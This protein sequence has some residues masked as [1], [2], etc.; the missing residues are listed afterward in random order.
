MSKMIKKVPKIAGVSY[1]WMLK[2]AYSMVPDKMK[3]PTDRAILPELKILP[4]RSRVII[5][6]WKEITE[7]IP[8]IDEKLIARFI[9]KRLGTVATPTGGKLFIQGNFPRSRIRR[10]LELFMKTYVICDICGR[11]DCVIE[12][13]KGKW[14]KKCLACGAWK[15]VEKI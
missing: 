10:V 2:R 12:R 11:P 14:V 13:Q 4:E 6:N 15:I 8:Q 9:A 7:R 3:T 5:M 1:D